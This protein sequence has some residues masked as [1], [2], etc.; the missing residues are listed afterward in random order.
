MVALLDPGLSGMLSLSNVD[1]ITL[2]GDAV[3][4]QVVS[5]LNKTGNLPRQE[6][7]SFYVMSN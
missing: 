4:H 5:R 3:K 2:T 1:L 6:A 7:Y